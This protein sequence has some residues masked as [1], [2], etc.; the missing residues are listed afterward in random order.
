M[1]PRSKQ[2]KRMLSSCHE[3]NL[4]CQKMGFYQQNMCKEGKRQNSVATQADPMRPCS[5]KN[6]ISQGHSPVL[7]QRRLEESFVLELARCVQPLSPKAD[8][9]EIY[10]TFWKCDLLAQ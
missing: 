5:L 1:E 7:T 3:I 10:S 2:L 8:T 6:R 4:I 9:R